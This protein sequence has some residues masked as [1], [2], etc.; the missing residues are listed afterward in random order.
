MYAVID[1]MGHQYIV[2]KGDQ[3]V[4]DRM[5]IEGDFVSVNAV[6]ATFDEEGKDVKLGSPFILGA[7]VDCKVIEHKK[8][9]KVEVL[10]FKRKT[11][12]ERNHGFRPY[13]TVLNIENIVVNG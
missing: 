3:I 12:Y 1:L 5:N 4:V 6:L 10:K 13:Q 2:K 7:K 8:G 11:R 9:E